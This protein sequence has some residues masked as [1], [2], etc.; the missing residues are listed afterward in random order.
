MNNPQFGQF[1]EGRSVL[2]PMLDLNGGRD[3]LPCHC[4]AV[5][6]DPVHKRQEEKEG[7]MGGFRIPRPWMF[8][9]GLL[10]KRFLNWTICTE[11]AEL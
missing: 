6:T 2:P 10:P 11:A 9:V 3:S 8:V 7:A 5:G 1:L 4:K